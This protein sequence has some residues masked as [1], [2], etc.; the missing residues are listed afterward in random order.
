[1]QELD[2]F[3]DKQAQQDAECHE[4][5][6]TGAIEFW[7]QHEGSESDEPAD[8]ALCGDCLFEADGRY[9]NQSTARLIRDVEDI[10]RSY[11]TE[12]NLLC[13]TTESFLGEFTHVFYLDDHYHITDMEPHEEGTR[14]QVVSGKK[15][16]SHSEVFGEDDLFVTRPSVYSDIAIEVIGQHNQQQT[17]R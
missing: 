10:K 12:D 4:C 16:D 15:L 8:Y 11:I 17:M 13:I 1:M 7:N 14:A 9:K 2:S 5:G 3:A 6:A